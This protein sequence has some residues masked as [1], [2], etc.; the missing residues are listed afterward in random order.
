MDIKNML[1][2][3]VVHIIIDVETFMEEALV[4]SA[5]K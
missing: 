3:K 4:I 1:F 5:S 2:N